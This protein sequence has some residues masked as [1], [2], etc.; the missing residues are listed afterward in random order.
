MLHWVKIVRRGV[1][2]AHRN[3]MESSGTHRARK[4]RAKVYRIEVRYELSERYA[5]AF[6]G[7]RMERR[8]GN[9]LLTGEIIDQPHLHGILDR[10][11]GLGLELLSVTTL[12]GETHDDETSH[13]PTDDRATWK[14]L[15]L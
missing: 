2:Y 12:S 8:G 9:T 3:N 13:P 10:L 14:G 15:E 1:P 4:G 5:G 11:N 7:M 6:E